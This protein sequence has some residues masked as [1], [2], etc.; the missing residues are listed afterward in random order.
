MATKIKKIDTAVLFSGVDGGMSNINRKKYNINFLCEKEGNIQDILK[1]NYPDAQIEGDITSLKPSDFKGNVDIVVMSPPCQPYSM[2]GKRKGRK[3]EKGTLADVAIK[4]CRKMNVKFILLEN[5]PG[6]LN[7]NNGEDFQALAKIFYDNGYRIDFKIIN[8]SHFGSKQNRERL[9]I[10]AI[11]EGV[12]LK[13]KGF[14]IPLNKLAERVRG[15]LD[16]NYLIS[17]D[18]S[19]IKMNIRPKLPPKA[20]FFSFRVNKAKTKI[21]TLPD[22]SRF[23]EGLSPFLDA[24]R[25]SSKKDIKKLLLRI[26]NRDL[27][28]GNNSPKIATLAFSKSTREEYLDARIRLGESLN[29]FTTG[30][31][32]SG[33]STVNY[34]LH[35]DLTLSLFEPEEVEKE[36]RW[37]KDWTLPAANLTLRYKVLGNGIDGKIIPSILDCFNLFE[38]FKK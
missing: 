35:A 27:V 9:F 37:P 21:L 13:S 2:Q 8:S 3:D 18:E 5:V 32:C 19:L 31:G 38:I 33:Q 28:R 24:I 12:K 36:M 1:V 16:P 6:L 4:L 10:V 25:G 29:T 7:N 22:V 20:R 14:E 23:E 17:R 11:R 15:D 30:S 34:N 26:I